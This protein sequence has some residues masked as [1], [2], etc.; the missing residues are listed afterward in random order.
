MTT[1]SNIQDQTFMFT[2]TLI[3]F[4]RD[5]AEALV[6]ANGGKVLSRL[7]AKL[8]YLVAGEDAGSKLA[9]ANALATVTIISEIEF[10]KMLP[11]G[12]VSNLLD[13]P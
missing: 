8:N 12:D 1:K 10:L 6:E 9:K 3:N 11:A 5:E 13:W 7:T 2:G 4:S